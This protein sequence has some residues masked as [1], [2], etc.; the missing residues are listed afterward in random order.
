MSFLSSEGHMLF[1]RTAE[2]KPEAK[3][4][5]S[6]YT[7]KYEETI[8]FIKSHEGFRSTPYYCISGSR[9]IGYGLLTKYLDERFKDTITVKQADSIVRER[10]DRGIIRAMK[11]YPSLLPY[12]YLAISHLFFCKGEG[13]VHKHAIHNQLKNGHMDYN[14]LIFFSPYEET[15]EYYRKIRRFEWELW[16]FGKDEKV[17]S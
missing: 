11:T 13:A 6:V 14:T 4:T 12:Q 16:N 1:G 8:A 7:L 9:T 15:R 17:K 3:A 10:I 5:L 2:E